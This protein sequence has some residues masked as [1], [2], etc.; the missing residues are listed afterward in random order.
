MI[1][2]LA[3]VPGGGKTH[4]SRGFEAA[5]PGQASLVTLSMTD[6]LEEARYVLLFLLR[7]PASFLSIVTFVARHHVRGLFFYSLHLA[8]R[9]A[10]KYAKAKRM[11]GAVII[12][13]GLV[14]LCVVIPARALTEDEARRL[15]DALPQP[16]A[17]MIAS[18]GSFHRFHRDDENIHPRIAQ[19]DASLGAWEAAV[20]KNA[21]TVAR[22]LPNARAIGEGGVSVLKGIVDEDKEN[23]RNTTHLA[24]VIGAFALF[25]LIGIGWSLTTPYIKSIDEQVY[26]TGALQAREGTLADPDMLLGYEYWP[27]L[28]PEVLFAFYEPLG[29]GGFKSAYLFALI[30]GTGLASYAAL[31]MLYLAWVPALLYSLVALMPR[32]AAG[33]ELF[34]AFT[35]REAIGR[36]AALPLF[37]LASAFMLRR[38]IDKRSLWPVFLFIGAGIFLHPVTVTLFALASLVASGV[39]L[40]LRGMSWWRTLQELIIA[41]FAFM[42]AGSYFFGKVFERLAPSAA[43]GA[44]SSVAYVDAILYRNTWEFPTATLDWYVHMLIVSFVFLLVLLAYH[45]APLLR[46][47]RARYPFPH[48]RTFLIWGFSLATISLTLAVIVPGL[49]L[50]A[51]QEWGAPYAF[52]QW[53]RISKFYYLGLF[54]MLIPAAALLY[55]WYLDSAYRMKR[56]FLTLVVLSGLASSTFGFELFQFVAG[57]ANYERAYVPQALSGVPDDTRPKDYHELCRTLEMLGIS[58]AEEVVSNDFGMRYYCRSNLYIT[59]EEGAAYTYR[60]R[61]ELV[62]W[63]ARYLAQRDTLRSFDLEAIQAYARSVGARVVV[64]TRNENSEAMRGALRTSRFVILPIP[65]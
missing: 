48:G 46:R 27:Y 44:V 45:F 53:S 8:L 36:E 34:G 11:R 22:V 2:E 40:L 29:H 31:R 33:T 9:A 51:M 43:E 42:L 57:Y 13:E 16:D 63:H 41:G 25:A 55:A 54:V 37:W 52:Q 49:N 65:Y 47:L 62:D 35:F 28:Y 1:I 19:G 5:Y 21:A 64:L 60:P 26:L 24:V 59:H 18:E 4:L 50:Y 23:R 38:I 30:M 3:G 12:D 32:A 39:A 14:H 10:G 17:L 7:H 61:A 6:R 58:S 15:I 56:A 20:R